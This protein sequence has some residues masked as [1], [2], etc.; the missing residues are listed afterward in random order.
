LKS[1]ADVRIMVVMASTA[2]G[3]G[4]LL[5]R[6]NALAEL[7]ELLGAVASEV[8]GRL[9]LVRGEAGVGKT[10]LVRRFCE[11]QRLARALWG[12]CDPLFTPQPLGPFLDIAR[13]SG[14]ELETLAAASPRPYELAASLMRELE[15]GVTIVVLEDV[16]WADEATL[17]TLRILARRI[18]SVQ[19]LL[20]ATY[21]H[22]EL[23]R[24][25]PLRVL[26][27]EV[28]TSPRTARVT[29]ESLSEDAVSAL[30]GDHDVDSADL[31]RKTGG[32][33]FFVTEALAAGGAE[34]PE[35][36]RDAVLA[37]SARLDPGARDLLEAIAIDPI[38]A[39]L[40]LLEAL[41]PASVNELEECLASGMIR[42]DADR[43]SFRHELARLAIEASLPPNHRLTL[44]ARAVAALSCPPAGDPDL[45][46][47]AHHAEAAG[48]VDAVLRFAPAAAARAAAVG[49]HREAAAQYA[50]ALRFGTRL[51][52]RERA[53]LQFARAYECYITD[54]NPEAVAAAR[55]ASACYREAGDVRAQG[56]ALVRLAEYLWCPGRIE[57]SWEAAREAVALLEPLE[58]SLELGRAYGHI[59]FLARS[60]AD[61]KTSAFWA[62]RA[63][64][65]AER[66]G[67]LP[68]LAGCLGG[69]GEAEILQGAAWSDKIDEAVELAEEHG[70]VEALGWLPILLGRVHSLNR[71]YPA[72]SRALT[73]G[74]E[75]AG[76]HGLELYRHYDLA[77]L[78]RVELDQGHWATAADLAEQVLRSR[79]ASTTPT[80][81]ALT[82]IGL[83]RAR[84][85]DPDPWS[86]LDEAHELAAMS[87]E[88]TRMAPVAAARAEAAWL[89][90]RNDAAA[91]F[92]EEAYVLAL[93][94]QQHAVVGELAVWRLRAG[95]F[96]AAPPQVSDPFALTLA[97]EPEGAA[98]W[99]AAHSCPFESALA[100]A[101][102]DAD[103]S[104][105]GA[106]SQLQ[107]LDARAAAAIVARHLRDRGAR[108]VPRGPRPATRENAAGLTPREAEV[109]ALL[110]R[111]LTN[112]EIANRL[113]VSVKTVDHH[114]AAILRKLG[115]RS[116]GEAAALSVRRG[117]VP[118][119]G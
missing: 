45:A 33:P 80:I 61:G 12:A 72:A 87:G 56:A 50:R 63:L 100:L 117:L 49:A 27:G 36:V 66:A 85:G 38:H 69:L 90:G 93:E 20:I 108:G 41:A 3:P 5:E 11:E 42:A 119:D 14:G 46:R 52:A 35:T 98:A 51:T 13:T 99:W 102:S 54:E 101:D 18:E 91:S 77:Y 88:L 22:D 68:M 78:S 81:V 31:Y 62:V 94:L 48:D 59:A 106:L 34:L 6:A 103:A 105:H 16:H 111:G 64:E 104:L 65:W 110:E 79:R 118:Q 75:F 26:L 40:W 8:A 10:T 96:E 32:N 97:G 113:F 24:R 107:E 89:E 109:L 15:T 30:A 37:R 74:I 67:D 70:L 39:E 44:H 17:D 95:M 21:R 116:R 92:T 58:P 76:E 115:V 83:L 23:D 19:L 29:V 55:E 86:P 112:G 114:V 7:D 9:V 71:N 25:H 1:G 73:N 84:R 2:A 57:E 47:L 43:I 53:E 4:V 82:V 60:A 28:T